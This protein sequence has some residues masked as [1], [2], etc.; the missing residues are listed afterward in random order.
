MSADHEPSIRI[1]AANLAHE[2]SSIDVL[3]TLNV[4]FARLPS[5][6]IAPSCGR[7][8]GEAAAMNGADGCAFQTARSSA[9]GDASA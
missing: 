5:E 7:S 4:A 3:V 9:Y 6:L 8:Q 1:R 2:I